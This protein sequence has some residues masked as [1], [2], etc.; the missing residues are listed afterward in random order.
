MK[1]CAGIAIACTG[2]A[3]RLVYLDAVRDGQHLCE[4][5]IAYANRQGMNPVADRRRVPR[6]VAA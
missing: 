2:I 5:C 4:P 6:T 1:R 3:A